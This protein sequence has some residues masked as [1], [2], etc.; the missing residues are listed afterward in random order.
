[1]SLAAVDLLDGEETV[2][3]IALKY[4]YSSP[5]AFNRAFQ[6]VHGLAPSRTRKEGAAIK[7]FPPITFKITIKG[8]EELNYR[9]ENHKSFRI[10][11]IAKPLNK[12]LEKN[13]SIVP[14][15]GRTPLSTVL[16]R[17]W[18]CSRVSWS[19]NFYRGAVCRNN[20]NGVYD[21]DGFR[22]SV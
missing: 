22:E 18:Q 5:T 12:E 16:C 8:A 15:C 7:S 4:G 19:S 6:T 10:V 2:T 11:G 21:E 14:K 17:S 1:M 3:D 20:G 13:F 9:I